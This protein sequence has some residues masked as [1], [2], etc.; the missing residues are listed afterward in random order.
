MGQIKNIK[1]HIVTDIKYV[2]TQHTRWV[3]HS[4]RSAQ[5]RTSRTSRNPFARGS[6]RKIWTRS[7]DTWNQTA[8]TRTSTKPS[9]Q[10]SLGTDSSI[11]CRVLDTSLIRCVSRITRRQRTTRNE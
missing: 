7:T 1:L 8:S 5:T 2:N 4:E 10:T 3:D 9:T 6:G 11:V